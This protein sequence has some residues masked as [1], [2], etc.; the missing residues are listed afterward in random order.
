MNPDDIEGKLMKF[1]EHVVQ[2]PPLRRC[3]A[4]MR[5]LHRSATHRRRARGAQSGASAE[6]GQDFGPPRGMLITGLTGTGKSTIS[7]E[8]AKKFP[9]YDAEDRTVIPVLRIELPSQPRPSVIAEQLLIALGDP[10]PGEGTAERRLA[11]AKVLMRAC[12]VSLIII[13]EV[14]H[15]TDNLD[16]RSRDVAADMLKNLMSE[17]IPV[18]FIGLSSSRA[19]F[20][21]NQQLGRRCTPKIHLNPFRV[22]TAEERSEFLA[23]LKAFHLGLP[24]DGDSALVEPGCALGFHH[25]TFGLVGH[26]TQLVEESLRVALEEGC[27]RLQA[28][29]VEVAF[30]KA[31]FP[32]CGS[33]R[34][35]F[36][37]HFSGVPLTKPGEPFHGFSA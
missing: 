9:R 6:V 16:A 33:K 17:G 32:E 35:P 22:A 8:Y 19:Y 3:D 34:N 10:M 37:K 14:Q 30:E 5:T 26:L 31:I 2:H 24:L 36:S 4:L 12:G 21:K 27:L 25:A 18:V 15:V 20:V 7:K 23:L 1:T 13:D 28:K 11:R 29:H